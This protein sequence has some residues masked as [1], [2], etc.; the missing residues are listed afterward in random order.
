MV[1]SGKI[2]ALAG[3]FSLLLALPFG[4]FASTEIYS[5]NFNTLSTGDLNGQD[6]WA[7]V[8]GD[9]SYY[10]YDPSLGTDKAAE[11]NKSGGGYCSITRRAITEI[12]GDGVMTFDYWNDSGTQGH[13]LIYLTHNNLPVY[14]VLMAVPS[15]GNS[16]TFFSTGALDASQAYCSSPNGYG[17]SSY[18]EQSVGTLAKETWG[19]ITLEWRV[20]DLK[21]RI[22]LNGGSFTEWT[23]L[24]GDSGYN[25]ACRTVGSCA[26]DGIELHTVPNQ[27]AYKIRHFIDNLVI[28]SSA[29]SAPTSEY[30]ATVFSPVDNSTTTAEFV[31]WGVSAEYYS[32]TTT[33]VDFRIT[34]YVIPPLGDDTSVPLYSEYADV[35]G[36]VPNSTT[37]YPFFIPRTVPLVRNGVW[38]LLPTIYTTDGTRLD[39]AT[40]TYQ[41]TVIGA[42]EGVLAP[43]MST[44]TAIT[45]TCDDQSGF[46]Q[47]SLCKLA[48]VLLIP[49][50]DSMT[51]LGGLWDLIKAKP[52]IGYLSQSISILTLDLTNATSSEDALVGLGEYTDELHTGIGVIIW[53]WVLLAIINRIR[54]MEL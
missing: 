34:L 40:T 46:F 9:G 33:P 11:M 43:Q 49:S 15:Y 3:V 5:Q 45:L 22:K 25:E 24:T 19:T 41:F 7:K 32:A 47:S 52:P 54:H 2:L 50:Q 12:S 1:K 20:S 38:K 27:S 39:T 8:G 17:M 44:S 36:F 53:L 51:R 18:S 28:T 35:S 37:S 30:L 4:V 21:A 31:Y 42:T 10:I 26:I 29:P 14:S 6:S 16:T 13:S 23:S 48:Q